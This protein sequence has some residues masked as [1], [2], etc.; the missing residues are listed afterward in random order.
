MLYHLEMISDRCFGDV[1]GDRFWGMWGERSLFWGCGRAIAFCGCERAIA[2]WG[3]W[4][5][6]RW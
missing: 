5:C 1:R 2:V 3:M 4:G 6:D